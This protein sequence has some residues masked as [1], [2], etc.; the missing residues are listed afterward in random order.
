M[1]FLDLI[2]IIYKTLDSKQNLYIF[3]L[4]FLMFVSMV[5]ET[6]SI[7]LIIPLLAII[8]DPDLFFSYKIVKSF[9]IQIDHNKLIIYSMVLFSIFFLIKTLILAIISFFQ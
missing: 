1:N 4:I 5:L 3:I 8:T 7:G 9:I 2:K 6:L